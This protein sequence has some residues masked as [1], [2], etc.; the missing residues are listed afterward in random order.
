MVYL[1]MVEHWC[2]IRLCNQFF[3]RSIVHRFGLHRT[4]A[5]SER[6]FLFKIFF[7]KIQSLSGLPDSVFLFIFYR[8]LIF[9]WSSEQKQRFLISV[10]VVQSVKLA[11]FECV[12]KQ[13]GLKTSPYSWS[14][15]YNPSSEI[16]VGYIGPSI[17]LNKPP[18]HFMDTLNRSNYLSIHM[19]KTRTHFILII[20]II[21]YLSLDSYKSYH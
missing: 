8:F 21:K 13:I 18:L 3:F 16:K 2:S 9:E 15:I 19:N 20:I 14:Q 6:A 1:C 7:A 17:L 10:A 12:E 11:G 4:E 5:K